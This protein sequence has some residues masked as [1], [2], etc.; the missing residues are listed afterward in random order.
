MGKLNEISLKRELIEFRVAQLF[1][2]GNNVYANILAYKTARTDMIILDEHIGEM[3]WQNAYKRDTQG[4]L[5]GGIGIYDKEKNEWIWKW[6]NGIPSNIEES[7][8]EYSDAFKRAGFM[9][10]IYRELYSFPRIVVLLKS[11]EYSLSG[12]KPKATSKLRPNDWVWEFD[13][14]LKVIT[15]VQYDTVRFQ[16]P[17][18]KSKPAQKITPKIQPKKIKK[19]PINNANFQNLMNRLSGGEDLK[20]LIKKHYILNNEQEGTMM[21]IID[22]PDINLKP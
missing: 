13:G 22:N 20:E 15:A 18:T 6:S 10:G 17:R 14:D 3:D 21:D 5:Q 12:T 4:T 1:K 8:G 16:F 7:K 11:D 9:W 2:S 19:A